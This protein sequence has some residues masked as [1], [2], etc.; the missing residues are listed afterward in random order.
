MPLASLV[1]PRDQA[2]VAPYSSVANKPGSYARSIIRLASATIS[3]VRLF[4]RLEGLSA[5]ARV[6]PRE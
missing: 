5:N 3:S 1:E 2:V 6:E 4:S